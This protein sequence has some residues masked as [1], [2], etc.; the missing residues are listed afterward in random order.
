MLFK[1]HF[2]EKVRTLAIVEK[3]SRLKVFLSK[4]AVVNCNETQGINKKKNQ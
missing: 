2:A 4:L 3:S 1:R